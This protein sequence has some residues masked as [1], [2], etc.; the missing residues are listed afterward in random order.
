MIEKERIKLHCLRQWRILMFWRIPSSI[1]G[2][3]LADC[4]PA[5]VPTPHQ[6]ILACSKNPHSQI[7]HSC[8]SL[9]CQLSC[10]PNGEPEVFHPWFNMDGG[11][12]SSVINNQTSM[13]NQG[14]K[15][16]DPTRPGRIQLKQ[17]WLEP[18]SRVRAAV[19]CWVCNWVGTQ[20]TNRNAWSKNED[21]LNKQGLADVVLAP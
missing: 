3:S 4:V 8:W 12:L 1:P 9:V 6:P 2:V 11:L 19:P 5:R 18:L 10:T 17:T 21:S 16:S 7:K 20:V 14:W 13:L 15:T